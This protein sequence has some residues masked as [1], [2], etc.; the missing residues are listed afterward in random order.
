MRNIPASTDA[1]EIKIAH[2]FEIELA[3]LSVSGVIT[4][5]KIVVD[6][7]DKC[8]VGMKIAHAYHDAIML[9]DNFEIREIT[10]V[11]PLLNAITIDSAFYNI[12]EKDII[13]ETLYDTAP[14]P[15][16]YGEKNY[17]QFYHSALGTFT[18]KVHFTDF[19]MP[20]VTEGD[21]PILHYSESHHRG[22]ILYLP[23][24]V[25]F[26]GTEFDNKGKSSTVEITV[27]NIDQKLG[28]LVL[29]HGALKQRDISV[30]TVYIEDLTSK[31]YN[32][33]VPMTAYGVTSVISRTDNALIPNVE[34]NDL[35][36]T[37]LYI[38]ELNVVT[39]FEGSVDNASSDSK[40]VSIQATVKID[41]TESVQ[42]PNR[43]YNRTRCL[44]VYKSWRCR[45]N[46]KMLLKTAMSDTYTGWITIASTS[47][48]FYFKELQKD[49]NSIIKIGEELLIINT[50]RP[51]SGIEALDNERVRQ[52]TKDQKN[53][54]IAANK[55]LFD[56]YVVTRSYGNTVATTHAI[57]DSVD[58]LLC[59]KTEHDCHLHGHDAY[60]GAFPA[61]PKNK[62]YTE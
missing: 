35:F 44:F 5:T 9:N 24:S 45:F 2:L 55:N 20:I 37:F 42:L 23:M 60:F 15:K 33:V 1:T 53:E 54:L 40:M 12:A 17:L 62:T 6:D 25:F 4:P 8:F 3:I 47:L 59:K 14:M 50:F 38:N 28:N 19:D 26:Q 39:E 57:N 43:M 29:S 34:L 51:Y 21:R 10:A 48:F 46:S 58:I 30:K 56:I 49:E 52:L 31:K 22:Q 27:S 36:T 18:G 7:I 32:L 61:I 16:I 13:V 41:S 11:E